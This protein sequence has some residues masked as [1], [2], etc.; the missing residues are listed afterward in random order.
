M[1]Q[2]WHYL[3]P[4][5]YIF[6][7]WIACSVRYK[8]LWALRYANVSLRWRHH[9][10]I[11][12]LRRKVPDTKMTTV[13]DW[14]LPF[15]DQE[16]LSMHCVQS[17][18]CYDFVPYHGEISS[19][20]VDFEHFKLALLPTLRQMFTNF[21]SFLTCQVINMMKRSAIALRLSSWFTLA[22]LPWFSRF[23]NFSRDKTPNLMV[24]SEISFLNG[25][26]LC[27]IKWECLLL[28][29]CNWFSRC[30]HW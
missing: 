2:S 11:S 18:W 15:R 10:L 9:S 13:V 19:L 25:M 8:L 5:K 28:L 29:N 12:R 4:V 14:L 7:L 21:Q 24:F 16:V 22:I 1:W 3:V 27:S 23:F 20:H 26:F 30:K 6:N 17:F